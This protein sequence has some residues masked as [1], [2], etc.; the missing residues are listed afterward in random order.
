[1]YR[2]VTAS[3][4]R[5][6][7]VRTTGYANYMYRATYRVPLAAVYRASCR[8]HLAVTCRA[9]LCVLQPALYRASYP[10][11]LHLKLRNL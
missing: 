4:S 7:T 1:M 2:A 3:A 10:F 9:T 6:C 5:A 8:V 11:V